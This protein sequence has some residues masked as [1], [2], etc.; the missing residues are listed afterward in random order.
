LLLYVFIFVPGHAGV[1]EMNKLTG[2]LELM[3]FQMDHADVLHV[4]HE[5]GR[6]EDFLEDVN[7]V[8]WQD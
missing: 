5:A 7:Q 3:L 8:L 6:V 4:L 2:L 1:I